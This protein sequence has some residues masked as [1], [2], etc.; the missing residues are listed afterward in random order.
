M[1]WLWIILLYLLPFIWMAY[2]GSQKG[3]FDD[4]QGVQMIAFM[5]VFGSVCATPLLVFLVFRDGIAE[6][7]KRWIAGDVSKD[8]SYLSTLEVDN[9]KLIK[10]LKIAEEENDRVRRILL[11][12]REEL[13][14][15][16]DDDP[17]AKMKREI[18]L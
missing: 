17:I 7:Y 5:I 18:G 10:R 4:V 14:Q 3:V 6:G 9:K 2:K 1:W 12:E 8:T 13:K 11:E 16:R 15:F